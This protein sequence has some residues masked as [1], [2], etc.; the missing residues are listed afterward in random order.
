MSKC[1]NEWS[2]HGAEPSVYIKA[3]LNM[4]QSIEILIGVNVDLICR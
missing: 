4:L 1:N 2:Y 3:Y